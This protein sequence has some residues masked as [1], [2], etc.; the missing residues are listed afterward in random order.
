LLLAK[1]PHP[2]EKGRELHFFTEE[3]LH[4]IIT[5]IRLYPFLLKE[6]REVLFFSDEKNRTGMSPT[7]DGISNF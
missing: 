4:Q 3:T 2:F 7:K 6:G 5:L 1:P